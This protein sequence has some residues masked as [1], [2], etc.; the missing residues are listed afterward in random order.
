[1]GLYL[2]TTANTTHW[3]SDMPARSPLLQAGKSS[4]RESER[5]RE[6]DSKSLEPIHTLYIRVTQSQMERSAQNAAGGLELLMLIWKHIDGRT[7]KKQKHVHCHP[8]TPSGQLAPTSV[9]HPRKNQCL[10]IKG[11]H[12]SV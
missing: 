2:S 8:Y 9:S 3:R 5:E 4:E 1:M 12:N 7:T 6:R 10:H 11:H